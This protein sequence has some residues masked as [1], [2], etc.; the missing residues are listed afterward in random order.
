MNHSPAVIFAFHS[1]G[2]IVV[3]R[4]MSLYSVPVSCCGTKI[5]LF[6]MSGKDL[7]NATSSHITSPRFFIVLVEYAC[8]M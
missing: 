1:A 7:W 5:S 3:S 2:V 6:D 4:G 8:S